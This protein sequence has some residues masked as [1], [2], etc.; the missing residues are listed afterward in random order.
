[1]SVQSEV[2]RLN[3]AKSDLA[4]A[5]TAKGVTVPGTTKLDGY[6]ALVE[7]IEAGGGGAY[8]I[9]ATDNGDGTQSL[10]IADATG[11]SSGGDELLNSVVEDNVDGT[12]T[13]TA[14]YVRKYGLAYLDS[15]TELKLPLATVAD[16]NGS[17]GSNGLKKV[18]FG[19]ITEIRDN[20]FAY[21]RQ[22]E[23]VIIRT[24]SVCTITNSNVFYQTKI[25]NGEGYIYVPNAL[26]EQYK[27]ATNW[28][29]FANQFRA[30]EDYPE[31]TGGTA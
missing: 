28:T 27:A 13:C 20:Q 8:D 19:S 16:I 11:G 9:T 29:Q 1:M 3:A 17:C 15:A 18:D 31:I 30:I 26:M 5:I 7:Q 2:S 12:L 4:S 22:V 25:Y 24:Q 21:S 23:T 14:T 6:A 10:A